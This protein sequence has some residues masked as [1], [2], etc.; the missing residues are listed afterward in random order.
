VPPLTGTWLPA[1]SGPEAARRASAEPAAPPSRAPGTQPS[2][3]TA[4]SARL[5]DAAGT[6]HPTGRLSTANRMPIMPCVSSDRAA[7]R[8]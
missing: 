4:D 1:G 3:R 2:A 6:T 5:E 8:G 7:P